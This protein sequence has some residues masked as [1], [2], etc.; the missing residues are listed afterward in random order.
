M[1]VPDLLKSRVNLVKGELETKSLQVPPEYDL[2]DVTVEINAPQKVVMTIEIKRLSAIYFL[3]IFIPS[4]CLIA[5]AGLTLFISKS[6]F[7]VNISVALTSTLVMYTLAGSVSDKLP[8][9]GVINMVDVWMIHGLIN[10]FAV[11]LALV[12]SN[13][14]DRNKT[15]QKGIKPQQTF[16]RFDQIC[17]I[18]IP[19]F[20][21][22]FTLTFFAIA[23]INT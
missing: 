18:A 20:T 9:T 12:L 6:H 23:A 2:V 8:V 1:A 17:Q 11:F 5:A 10:P 14:K 7:E 21:V 22:I 15:K 4:L 13:L 3:T 16:S 19:T